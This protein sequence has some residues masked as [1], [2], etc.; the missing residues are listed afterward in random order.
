MKGKNTL[1]RREISFYLD[2]MYDVYFYEIKLFIL[3][4]YWN[5]FFLAENPFFYFNSRYQIV[6]YPRL[7]CPF[8]SRDLAVY[9]IL[10]VLRLIFFNSEVTKLV[11]EK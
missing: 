9:R 2:L 6:D 1:C 3:R 4:G 7:S 5:F 11:R 8:M 10:P